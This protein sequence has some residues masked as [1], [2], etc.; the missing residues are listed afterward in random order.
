MVVLLND[1]DVLQYLVDNGMISSINLVQNGDMDYLKMHSYEIWQGKDGR[2][3]TY[4]PTI[5][6]RKFIK[7]KNRQDIVNAIIKFY[8]NPTMPKLEKVFLEAIKHKMELN[9]ICKGTFDRYKVDFYKYFSDLRNE[10]I[11]SFNEKR[12]DSIIRHKIV[13]FELTSKAYNNLR[14]VLMLTFKYAK[15]EGFTELSIT[16]FFDELDISP[17]VFAR[18][19]KKKQVFNESEIP[20]VIDYMIERNTL[21]SLAIAFDFYSGL[22]S[23]ELCAIRYDDFEGSILHIERQEIKEKDDNGICVYKIVD[24]TKTE[25]GDRK[26]FIPP[27]GMNIIRMIRKLNPFGEYVFERNGY[28]LHANAFNKTLYNACDRLGIDRLSMHKIRKTYG[29]TL[30]DNGV[31]TSLIMTQMGHSDITTTQKYYY[32]SNKDNAKKQAQIDGAI[33]FDKHFDKHDNHAV[34]TLVK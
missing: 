21:E 6:K 14:T 13:E 4:L 16:N 25:A 26:V 20:K 19:Q 34:L 8:K 17:K 12:L 1:R 22:R 33:N 5:P 32:F 23:G 3:C 31:D 18:T 2:W 10:T 7:L 11:E 9:E 24:Y 15:K 29:T 30:I 28:R 27:E